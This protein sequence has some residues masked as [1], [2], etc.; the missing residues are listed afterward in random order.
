MENKVTRKSVRIPFFSNILVTSFE[1]WISEVEDLINK[2]IVI[3]N[4][5][6]F[7]D[8]LKILDNLI[9]YFKQN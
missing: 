6:R 4:Q 8:F 3:K 9:I 5:S 1:I 2:N 7:V